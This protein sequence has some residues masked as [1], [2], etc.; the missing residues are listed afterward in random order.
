PVRVF[1]IARRA[2]PVRARAGL[3]LAADHDL[4]QHP[5]PGV[6]VVPGGVVA[7]GL[8]RPWVASWI[9]A[10]AARSELTV[11]I[12]NGS[13]LLAQAGLSDGCTATTNW[14]DLDDMRRQY[15]AVR[16]VGRAGLR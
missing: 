14:E 7:R 11:S 6:L 4:G 1:T 3:V 13:F 5:P 8:E 15:P 10:A 2:E 9:A 12:C 16:V